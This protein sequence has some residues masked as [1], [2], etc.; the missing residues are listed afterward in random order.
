MLIAL[1]MLLPT[2]ALA[3][4]ASSG[5]SR[6]AITRNAVRFTNRMLAKLVSIDKAIHKRT[7]I[8]NVH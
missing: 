6:E 1:L 7:K 5:E 3:Q 4:L 8:S 2:F